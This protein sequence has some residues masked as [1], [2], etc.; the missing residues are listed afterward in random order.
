LYGLL[1]VYA[2]AK[3][4]AAF[5]FGPITAGLLMFG[6]LF[7]VMAPVLIRFTES[8]A[9]DGAARLLGFIGYTWMGLIFLFVCSAF[10]VDLFRLTL[11]VIGALLRSDLTR[12]TPTARGCFYIPLIFTLL[13]VA[14]GSFEAAHI[15][16]RRVA[17]RTSKISP[18]PGVLRIAQISDVH[19]GLLV[20]R[21]RLTRILTE[22]KRA[23]PDMVVSTGDLVDGQMAGLNGLDELLR[24]IKPRYGKFAVTGNHDFYA[25]IKH[26]LEFARKA[27]FTVLRGE[28]API[29]E[30]LAIVGVDDPAGPGYAQGRENAEKI[31]LSKAPRDNFLLFLKHR[32]SVN[33]DTV[34]L[35]DLQLS[36]HVHAGQIFPFRLIARLFYPYVSGYFSLG[37]GSFLYVSKGS[38]TWGPPIRFL[39]PPEVTLITLVY[40]G[41]A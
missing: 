19:L 35:F 4:R 16:T 20:R 27:G 17:V 28:A 21:G 2:F 38:G 15:Q 11:R 40:D 32:P 5:A 1:H 12:F 24:D 30:G 22:V 14:Y 3:A 6:M 10:V 33:P 31:L 13:V 26:S 34:G 37:Q 29:A 23:N 39:S 25:G 9:W 41:G 36:G 8:H 7:M 18:R